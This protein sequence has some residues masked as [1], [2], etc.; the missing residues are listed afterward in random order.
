[1]FYVVWSF[2]H[3]SRWIKLLGFGKVNGERANSVKPCVCVLL[4]FIFLGHLKH[5]IYFISHG[6]F[7]I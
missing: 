3:L 2:R 1:M 4:S 6:V 7:L 5:F